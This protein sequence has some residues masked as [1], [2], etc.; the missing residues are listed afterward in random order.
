MSWLSGLSATGRPN[1]RA[2]ARVSSLARPPSGKRRKS[3]SSRGRAIQEIALVARRVARAVQFR[4]VR[5]GDA[6][7]VMP[8]GQRGGAEIARGRQQVAELD[9][10]VAAD[11]RDRRLAAAVALG[12]ILDHRGAKP[13][14]VIE[15]VMRDAETLGDA[16]GVAISWPAQQAPLRPAA[17]PWS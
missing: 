1:S 4:P 7:G 15:H 2:T 9:A 14:L 16:R 5:P 6:A 11:A 12:E 3:S 17:A 10:L 13:A 8:G